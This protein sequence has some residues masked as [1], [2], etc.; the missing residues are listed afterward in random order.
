MTAPEPR[1]NGLDANARGIIVLVAAVAIGLLLLLKTGS[2]GGTTK[3]DASKGSSTPATTAALGGT[4]TSGS[5]SVTTTTGGGSTGAHTPGQVKVIV[6]NGSG[7]VGVAQS[8]S[9]TIGTKGY[10]ML[11]AANA[12]PKPSTT[13][14][15]FAPGYQADAEAVAGILGKD[16]SVVQPKPATALGPG[17]DSANVIVVLGADTPAASSTSTTSTTSSAGA[18]TSTT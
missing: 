15:Y 13:S 17:T 9:T 12:V 14:V 7:K 16:S 1:A 2:G 3:I 6:L 5:G 10:K 4:T 8:N 18:T 11:T